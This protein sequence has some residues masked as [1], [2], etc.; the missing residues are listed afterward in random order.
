MYI[1]KYW[2]KSNCWTSIKFMHKKAFLSIHSSQDWF[3]FGVLTWVGPLTTVVWYPEFLSYFE[4]V[5]WWTPSSSATEFWKSGADNFRTIFFIGMLSCEII[6]RLLYN[7][8]SITQLSFN[9][10]KHSLMRAVVRAG[11][12]FEYGLYSFLQ[13]RRHSE[14]PT[15]HE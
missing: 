4:T 9:Q 2:S 7:K 3:D 8:M 11:S 6:I 14:C 12:V 15:H 5:L 10:N 13:G 1:R